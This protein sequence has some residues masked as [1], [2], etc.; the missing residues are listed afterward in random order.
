M[1]PRP[2]RLDVDGKSRAMSTSRYQG[3]RFKLCKRL[4]ETIRD[5]TVSGRPFSLS[6]GKSLRCIPL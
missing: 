3:A 4:C 5:M 6:Q 1:S 2:M